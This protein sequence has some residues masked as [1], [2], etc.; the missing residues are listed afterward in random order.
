MSPSCTDTLEDDDDDGNDDIIINATTSEDF[1]MIDSQPA[2]SPL[3]WFSPSP[4]TP[5]T[6]N[7]AT[8]TRI[9]TPIHPYFSRADI[10]MS[11]LSPIGNANPAPTSWHDPGLLTSYTESW[12]PAPPR[13]RR[14]PSPISEG[15]DD[16]DL[17]SPATSLANGLLKGLGVSDMEVEDGEVASTVTQE[18]GT[19]TARSDKASVESSRE[20]EGKGKMVFS[21]GFRADCEKCRM[22]V[23]GH[24]S[25]VFRV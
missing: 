9:P 24:Y 22:R 3:P 13:A 7:P 15:A 11:D 8:N 1:D 6:N 18:P 17:K 16:D 23:P 12:N 21:M 2:S 19:A 10:N 5:N 20:G 25:H 4:T 14:L